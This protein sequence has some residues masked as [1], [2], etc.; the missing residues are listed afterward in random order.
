MATLGYEAVGEFVADLDIIEDW[1]EPF[2]QGVVYYLKAGHVRGVLLSNT[3]GQLDAVR[4]LID[5]KV[6]F[7]AAGLK[8]RIHA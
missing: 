4:R 5:T 2:R 6:S 3:L 7:S 8:R 1:K